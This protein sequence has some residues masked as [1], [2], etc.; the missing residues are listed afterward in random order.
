MMKDRPGTTSS[1]GLSA[2]ADAEG[3]FAIVAMDQRNTLRR[4]FAAAG[5]PAE[6]ADLRS[7]KVDVARALTPLASGILLDATL[8][9][10]A[11]T[12]AAALAP[13]CGLLVAAEPEARGTW[14]G[15]PRTHRDPAQDAAWVQSMGGDAVKFL[16]QLR[17]GRPSGGPDLAMEVL[18]VVRDVVA[19][20]RAQ[21]IA[22]V[23]ENLVYP[24]PGERLAARQRED[25]I[26]E[27]ARL[28]SEAGADL[29]KLEYPGSVR[30]ARRVAQVVGGPWA[31]LSAGVAFEEFQDVLRVSCD[32]G[33]ACGF[34]AGRSIWKEVVGLQGTARQEFLR[35]VARPRFERCLQTVAGRA[36]PWTEAVTSR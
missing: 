6:Q 27:A 23:I 1:T 8:G 18:D 22:S 28:L 13:S 24:L 16:V 7:A 10:P 9:V 29:V 19:D 17:P 2:I 30:G 14:N 31:V 4:M 36:R 3:I 26:V 20:C 12:E 32:E 33:G 34:I 5:R 15:E 11:V 21:G 25:L 35:D